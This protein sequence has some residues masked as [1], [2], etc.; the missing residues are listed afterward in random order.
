MIVD[1]YTKF[2]NGTNHYVS[3]PE[4][5]YLMSKLK[6]NGSIQK[7]ISFNPFYEHKDFLL[8][9]DERMLYIESR[10]SLNEIESQKCEED[11]YNVDIEKRY[12]LI[13]RD[14]VTEYKKTLDRI[15]SYLD[16]LIPY[17][18]PRL[19]SEYNIKEAG[20]L[21]GNVCFEIYYE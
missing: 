17:I 21:F 18:L 3:I 15:I 8:E 14:D 4:F 16:E 6:S 2:K 12:F 7:S 11:F 5:L 19:K 10:D 13:Q 1:T 20:L 9:I